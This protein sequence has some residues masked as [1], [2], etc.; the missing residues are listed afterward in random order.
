MECFSFFEFIVN[1]PDYG[2]ENRSETQKS[3]FFEIFVFF[4]PF[5]RKHTADRLFKFV[6]FVIFCVPSLEILKNP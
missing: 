5:G 4:H 6:I 3:H 1:A 2:R